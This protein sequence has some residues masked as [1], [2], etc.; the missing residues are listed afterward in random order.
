M[1]FL[2]NENYPFPSVKIL[3]AKGYDVT[4]IMEFAQGISDKEVI[5][6]AS[7]EDRIILTFD[8]DYGEL[9]FRYGLNKPP[10]VVY[11]RDKG[12]NPKSA[13]NQLLNVIQKQEINIENTFT[14]IESKNIRQRKYNS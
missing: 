10:S 2:A 8:R 7:K 1:K 4:F 11:F 5:E 14:D 12:K 6:I 9:I 3:R 13:A